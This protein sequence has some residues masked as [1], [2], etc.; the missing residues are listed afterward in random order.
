MSV[1][2]IF[3]GVALSFDLVAGMQQLRELSPDPSYLDNLYLPARSA[4][5]VLEEIGNNRTFDQDHNIAR[6]IFVEALG[7]SRDCIIRAA[8]CP[9]DFEGGVIRFAKA[10]ETKFESY[11]AWCRRLIEA[12]VPI[13]AVNG[14]VQL[15]VYCNDANGASVDL[16]AVPG[17]QR[18]F[19]DG[20]LRQIETPKHCSESQR[21]FAV[22]AHAGQATAVLTWLTLIGEFHR[23]ATL[24]TRW[25]GTD[26]LYHEA[27]FFRKYQAA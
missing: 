15:V 7:T 22:Q 27:C 18:F 5:L 1:D 17:A 14:V 13:M 4:F 12:P 9:G 3:G 16:R 21:Y 23:G 6:S 25:D 20:Q 8:R 26:R 19:D 2:L 11:V 10:R 24:F